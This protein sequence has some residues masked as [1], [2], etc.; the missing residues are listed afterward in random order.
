MK[1]TT[2]LLALGLFTLAGVVT[3]SCGGSSDDGDSDNKAGSSSAGKGS[4]G[5]S[6]GGTSSA[7]TT[8]KT[9]GSSSSG[10][11]GTA[12]T[13]G[14]N[15]GRNNNQGGNNPGAGGDFNLDEC[16]DGVIDGMPCERMQGAANT[17]QVNDT[18]YCTCQGRNDDT[19]WTCQDFGDIGAGGNGGIFGDLTCPANPKTGDACTGL[20]ACPGSQT[21]ACAGGTVY[22]GGPQQ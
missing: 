18:T 7:G 11:S 14:N 15:G 9:G 22:C 2:G 13:T 21:C 10:G 5:G 12:G 3:I 6:N 16:G 4:G 17:C 1:A 19:T 8:S 20:G